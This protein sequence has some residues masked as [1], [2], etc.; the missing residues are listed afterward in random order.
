MNAIRIVDGSEEADVNSLHIN[1]D[2]RFFVSG[3]GDKKVLLWNYDEGS[4]Y[5]EGDG[6]SGAVSRVRISPDE[7]R[8]VS[9]GSEG[10]IFIWKVPS[11]YAP[12]A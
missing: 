6:H 7:R 3:G 1:D 2:G 11:D 10:G 4:K 9:V 12:A 5:Y 8:V